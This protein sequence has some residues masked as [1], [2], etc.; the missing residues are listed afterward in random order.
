M[1][2]LMKSVMGELEVLGSSNK[3]LKYDSDNNLIYVYPSVSKCIKSL[4]IT[5]KELINIS[6]NH[7]L[8]N[9]YYYQL[10][11]G[12]GGY[13]KVKCVYCGNEFYCENHRLSHSH[14]FCSKQCESQFIISHNLNSTCLICGKKFH[15]KPHLI[16]SGGGKYCSKKCHYIA[17]ETYM[18]GNGNHQYG[19]KGSLNSSWKSDER[20]S[21]YGYKL[22]RNPEH[23][24]ANTDGFVFEHRLIAEKFLLLDEN[25]SVNI[26]GAKYLNPKY[27]VHHIDF[28]RQNNDISNLLI[29]K[30]EDHTKMHKK[31]LD[32][33]TLKKYCSLYD[34]SYE[35]ILEYRNL[36]KIA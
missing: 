7:L 34:V 32:E 27:V 30:R 11:R 8:Y 19:L 22:I 16:K 25:N 21:Y 33:T 6:D 12:I 18:L 14:L 5:K 31:L 36:F 29:M 28:N 1:T 10:E 4:N 35:H 20:I 13:T 23:P 9:K 3:V 15:A 26:N 17:K 24:Y 2:A